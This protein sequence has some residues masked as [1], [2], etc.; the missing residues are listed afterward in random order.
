MMTRVAAGPHG[1][2]AGLPI[3]IEARQ[4]APAAVGP[5]PAPY[6]Y[7]MTLV[8]ERERQ[9]TGRGRLVRQAQAL[10]RGVDSY[11]VH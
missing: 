4:Q 5:A 11:K 10:A 9:R 8:G 2:E 3:S 7:G 1:P 6:T